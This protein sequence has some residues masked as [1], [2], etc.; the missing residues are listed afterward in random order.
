[1][2]TRPL[3]PRSKPLREPQRRRLSSR[4]GTVTTSLSLPLALHRRAIE[5]A[6]ARN[7]VLREVVRVA[8]T[9]WLDRQ[10]PG[11]RRV[12]GARP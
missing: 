11:T 4:A 12:S 1:M 5:A 10:G 7:W 8:L 2:P 3:H 9:E 6:L